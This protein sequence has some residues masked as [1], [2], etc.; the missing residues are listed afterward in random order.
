VRVHLVDGTFEL[1][2]A[3]YSQRPPHVSPQG[4]DL[5]A[6]LGVVQSLLYLLQEKSERATHV[7]VAFDNPI[8][9]FRN[10]LFAGYKTDAGIDPALRSQFD[11]VEEA[12]AALGVVVWRMKEFEADDALATAALRFAKDPRVEQV[13]ILTPD[14][15]LAQ[16][17]S[18]TRI[19]QVDRIRKKEITEASLWT[20]KHLRPG[21][22]PD[23]LALV[24]DTADGIPGLE[25]WGEKSTAEVLAVHPHVSDIPDSVGAWKVKPRSA[26][27][28]AA[29]LARERAEAMLYR[30]LATLRD[31]VPLPQTLEQL[32]WKGAPGER[33]RKWCEA[34]GAASLEK[35]PSRFT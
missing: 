17:L 9:S 11:D 35:R 8:V 1:F 25:G 14:K 18:G 4:R 19:V 32:E 20:D 7:A 31:D 26:E 22:V 3:H 29:V 30:K 5:K 13:R 34:V 33:W 23:F 24:G 10:E 6:T 16:V 28:L 15:D 21:S 2:R 12:V 27:K